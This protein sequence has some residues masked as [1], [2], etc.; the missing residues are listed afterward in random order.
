MTRASGRARALDSAAATRNSRRMDTADFECV[1][2]GAGVVGL[3]IACELA[4]RGSE[5]CVLEAEARR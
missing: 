3:S 2:V 1:V 5:V 4:W